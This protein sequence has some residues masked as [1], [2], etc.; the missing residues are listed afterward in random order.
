MQTTS[1][2]EIRRIASEINF[3]CFKLGLKTTRKGKQLE[4]YW[5]PEKLKELL[6][7]EAERPD[8]KKTHI[9]IVKFFNPTGSGT[10]WVSEYHDRGDEYVADFFGKCRLNFPEPSLGYV[11]YKEMRDLRVGFGLAIERDYHFTP[12]LL[13]EIR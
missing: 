9:A 6:I 7:A 11:N 13:D 8:S 5:L 1:I 3:E 12:T 2:E 10:W 4:R